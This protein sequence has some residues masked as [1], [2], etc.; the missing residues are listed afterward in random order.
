MAVEKSLFGKSPKGEE[1][2]LYTLTNSKGMKVSLTDLGAILVR[3]LAPDAA[4]QVEDVVLGFDQPE[5]YYHNPSFFGAVIGPCANRIGGAKFTLDGKEYQ[6]DVNDNE[7][8]LHSHKEQ[9]Y[10]KRIWDAE[11]GDNSVTFS[12]EDPG[13]MG[14]P[15][16]KKFQITYSLSEENELKLQYHASSDQKTILNPTNHTYFNLDG[17]KSGTIADHELYLAASMYTPADAGSIPTGEIAPVA[18]TPMDFTSMKRI[19]QEIDADFEQLKLAGGYD[20]NWVIDGWNG[21]LRHIATL[22]GPKSG[23]VLKAYTTLPG[24]QFYAGNFITTETGKE[25]VTYEKRFGLC[26]ETQYYPDAIHHS[27]FPSCVFGGEENSQYDS[28]TVYRFE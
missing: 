2:S 3:L 6:L 20:H 18:G 12:L 23:R 24:V 17:A 22:K 9:G 28:V 16:N 14:F 7:N 25:N 10:H 13:T 19:G 8:N 11:I 1:I 5:P 27:E 15:G 26:L 21:E 4:G